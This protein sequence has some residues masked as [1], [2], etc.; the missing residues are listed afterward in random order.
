MCFSVTVITSWLKETNRKE[1]DI[2]AYTSKLHLINDRN[3]G[4]DPNRNA[5]RN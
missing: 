4:K 3:Q 5:N 2:S 1:G